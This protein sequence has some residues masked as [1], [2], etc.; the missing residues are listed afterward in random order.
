[1][2]K[3]NEAHCRQVYSVDAALCLRCLPPQRRAGHHA[4]RSE[5]SPSPAQ[6]AAQCA[7]CGGVATPAFIRVLRDVFPFLPR[8][9]THISLDPMGRG[10]IR[11]CPVWRVL[12]NHGVSGNSWTSGKRIVVQIHHPSRQVE[13][14]QT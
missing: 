12:A 10:Q 11:W 13:V 7:E 14:W 1:M 2:R 4:D 6:S 8:H 3:V 9:G 5:P